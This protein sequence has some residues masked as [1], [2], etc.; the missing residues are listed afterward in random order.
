MLLNKFKKP[1][2]EDDGKDI[3]DAE[4]TIEDD[5][6]QDPMENLRNSESDD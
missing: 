5:A 4:D 3:K 6:D 2:A 1:G